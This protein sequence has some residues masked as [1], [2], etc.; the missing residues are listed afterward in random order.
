[1]SDLAAA[2][3]IAIRVH[4]D[5]RDKQGQP[6]LLHVLRVVEAV[7]EEAKVVA[8]LHDVLE[9]GPHG[10]RDRLEDETL[11]DSTELGAVELLTR[12]PGVVYKRY[13]DRIVHGLGYPART[14]RLDKGSTTPPSTTTDR[15]VEDAAEQAS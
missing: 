2:L 11:L 8:A 12:S 3:Q 5:Q 10:I 4:A 7:S 9:D 13:I 6:Y 14:Y 15:D 1:M